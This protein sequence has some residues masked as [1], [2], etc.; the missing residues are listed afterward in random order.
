[1]LWL[2]VGVELKH[3]VGEMQALATHAEGMLREYHKG[4]LELDTDDISMLK[5]GVDAMAELA[6]LTSLA[7][8]TYCADIAERRVNKFMKELDECKRKNQQ[9][10]SSG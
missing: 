4:K 8:A 10:Q 9:Q 6:K 2:F 3:R 5:L 7:L 1:M